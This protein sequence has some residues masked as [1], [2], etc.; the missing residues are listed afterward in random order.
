MIII[1][2]W[3]KIST[4]G[5]KL[6]KLGSVKNNLTIIKLERRICKILRGLVKNKE[7]ID[8]I[9]PVGSIRPRLYSFPKLHNNGVPIRSIL[10]Y[11]W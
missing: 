2:K 6:K 10:S 3:C 9:G 4:D 7:N 11:L 5:T 8:L 1:Q